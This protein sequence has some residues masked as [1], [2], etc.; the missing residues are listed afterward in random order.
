MFRVGVRIIEQ[1][2]FYSDPNYSDPDSNKTN[3][4]VFVTVSFDG[5]LVTS[6][7]WADVGAWWMRSAADKVFTYTDSWTNLSFEFVR[8]DGRGMIS[9]A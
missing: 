6:P 1:G 3:R 5:Y 7:M 2:S 9:R 4:T 8:D